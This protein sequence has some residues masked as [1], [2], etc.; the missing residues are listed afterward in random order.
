[1]VETETCLGFDGCGA[2]CLIVCPY[3]APQFRD[4]ADA[5]MEK[6]DLCMERWAEGKK[7]ICVNACP[8]RAL[9]AGPQDELKAKYGDKHE[10]VGFS[11]SDE[12]KPS[13]VIKSRTG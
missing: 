13:L 10:A 4:K 3:D 5:R 12:I 8:T 7:P 11:Y 1:M 6:C 9:D 2:P